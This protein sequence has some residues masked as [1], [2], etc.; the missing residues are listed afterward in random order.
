MKRADG[1]VAARLIVIGF[2]CLLFSYPVQATE[3]RLY[4]TNYISLEK[5]ASELGMDLIW[6]QR[7]KQVYLK[8]DWTKI[9][10]T[11]HKRF[12]VLNGSRVYLGKPIVLYKNQLYLGKKDYRSALLPILAPQT[13][14]NVPKLYRI[15]IDPGHGGRDPGA[16][17]RA[18]GL[19]EK[20]VAFNVARLL[21]RSLTELGYKVVL[22]REQDAYVPLEQRAQLARVH[23][24]DLFI[25]IHFNAAKSSKA[26]GLET[27]VFTL[28][29]H[30]SSNRSK[31][32]ASDKREYAGN[33]DNTWST[34]A[35]YSV[36]SS[37]VA[38]LGGKDRGLKR[39]RFTV[40][41]D[42]DCPGFLIEG[43]FISN[44]DEGMKIKT[45]SYQERLVNAITQGV[46]AYQKKLNRARGLSGK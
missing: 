7:R 43:G 42:L 34:L 28:P 25:S 9:E 4:G 13:F 1:I 16:E 2:A 37:M 35:S 10:C 22:T 11:L 46:L 8:S 32:V 19:R 31:L 18:I 36:H 39:A 15:V 21:K 6:S 14:A 24:A 33:A 30:P 29:W 45:Q 5:V 23:R 3:V 20:D 27:Y 44:H 38:A 26:E 12:C 17:N 41:R 40:L